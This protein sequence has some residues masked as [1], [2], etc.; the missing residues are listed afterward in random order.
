LSVPQS[1]SAAIDTLLHPKHVA[2]IGVSDN[3]ASLGGRPLRLLDQHRFPGGLYPVNPR[4][5][6]QGREAYSNVLEVP[7]SPDIAMVTVRADRVPAVLRDCVAAGVK[8]AIVCSSG[9]GEG[10]GGGAELRDELAAILKESDLRIIGPNCEGLASLPAAAPLTFSPV[11]DVA[12]TGRP[13]RE[14]G[15]SVLS[16]SGGLGFAVA[17]WGSAVGVGFRYIVSTGNELD[18]DV[19]DFAEYLADD[20]GTEVVAMLV[21]GF[22]RPER[23]EAIRRRYH[24]LGKLLVVVKLGGSPPGFVGARAHTGHDAGESGEYERLFEG[25]GVLRAANEEQLTDMLQ[26]L[27]KSPRLAGPRIG[28]V[29]TSGGAGVW[30]ADV[31]H[32]AGLELPAFSEET[33]ERLSR[34]M[35]AFGSPINP[36][37][38][39]A[40]F[41]TEGAFTPV[42]ETVIDSGEVDGVILVSSLSTPGRLE[43]DREGLAALCQ[44]AGLPLFV[45]S[46][47]HPAATTVTLLEELRL[48]WYTSSAR[49]AKG[50]ASLLTHSSEKK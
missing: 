13:L 25:D 29:T 46:Y 30:T 38:L 12:R 27:S 49:A 37:D 19:L 26:A 4:G 1:V 31:C 18:L 35:P 43:R 47:T 14:G 8:A 41:L 17:E 34:Y 28:V 11:L 32:A 21:E 16:Q 5:A 40:Q 20:A 24:E 7:T 6:V 2:L 33:Q 48:P 36:V 44:R 9:F 42:V 10:L 50:M 45:L 22:G 3:A 15:V 39:T 23:F